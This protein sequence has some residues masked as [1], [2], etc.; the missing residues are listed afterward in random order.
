[1]ITIHTPTPLKILRGM[2]RTIE[3]VLRK[4]MLLLVLKIE[5]SKLLETA[6]SL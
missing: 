3:F 4:V 6:N 2:F 5:R 1:L